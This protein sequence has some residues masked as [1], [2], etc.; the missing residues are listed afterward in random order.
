MK[1]I[2]EMHEF[3]LNERRASALT[4]LNDVVG[5]RTSS[6]EGIKLSVGMASAFLDWMRL[7][8]YGKKYGKLPFNMLFT[9]AFVWGLDRYVKGKDL[10]DEYKE[11]KAKAKEMRKNES[12]EEGYGMY[13]LDHG[14]TMGILD[15]AAQYTS[16]AHA[17]ANQMWRDVDDLVSYL[18]SDH[19]PRKYHKAF[20]KSV[21]SYKKRHKLESVSIDEEETLIYDELG[22]ELQSLEDKLND[23]TA[24]AVDP[25]WKKALV[26]IGNQLDKVMMNISK[27]D[28]KLG[29]IELTEKRSTPYGELM[30]DLD[31]AMKKAI[32]KGVTTLRYAKDYVKSLERMAKK[33][34]KQFFKDYGDFTE[35]DWIEDVRYNMANENVQDAAFNLDKIFGDDQESIQMFQDIEDNGTWK[36]MVNY[37][38]E[39][40]NEEMLKRYG[41]RSTSQVTKLAKHLMNES[42]IKGKDAGNFVKM[43]KPGRTLKIDDDVYTALGKGKWEGPKG[44]KLNWIEVSSIASALGNKKVIYESELKERRRSREPFTFSE[45]EVKDIAD[46]IAKAISKTDKVKAEVHDMEYV[47]GEGAS[48][49]ISMDGEKYDGGSYDV[50]PNGEVVN[51]A[52][53]NSF[54]N[55]IYAK[56]GDKNINQIM[57]NIKKFESAE[58]NEIRAKK[59]T[60]QMWKKFSD[61]KRFDAL[62]SVIKDPDDAEEYVF[63]R[64]EKLPG[65]MQR[66]MTLFELNGYQ[67]TALL[68]AVV[69]Q[70]KVNQ[71]LSAAN[72]SAKKLSDGRWFFTS[73]PRN[74]KGAQDMETTAKAFDEY[75][76]P[77][78]DGNFIKDLD[79]KI[80]GSGGSTKILDLKTESVLNEKDY[81]TEQ[82]KEMAAKGLALPDGSFPIK[83]IKDLKNAILSYGRSTDHS[84]VAK[85]IAKRAKALGA[86]D[87]IPDTENFQKALK[88]TDKKGEYIPY[89]ESFKQ[90]LLEKK[91]KGAPDFHH[92]D[93]PDAEGRFRDLSPKD[94]A[95]WLI[96]TRKKDLKKISGSLTQQVV[97]NRN[98]D[99]KYAD[100]MEKTRIEVYKQLGREDLLDKKD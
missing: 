16:D 12:V 30:L 71:V 19:I 96:K 36:D 33:N 82:R 92:S 48:F 98:D 11:L 80:K 87:L 66:D 7:S 72:L 97:F 78:L 1:N 99:P 90:S 10:K 13:G 8:P 25:N 51:V 89:Y 75:A 3:L 56:I 44:E 73:G 54:P 43:A 57:K 69:K 6:V 77:Q 59:V 18:K 40:G 5:G 23:L 76:L 60:K 38:E 20:D 4:L 9:A 67:A 85:F 93:A 14:D 53:G 27:Y 49:E 62:L 94:L 70:A 61:D 63:M 100:K 35:D 42:V 74:L 68:D 79:F 81:S 50:R 55:A 26:S 34:A 41:I 2:L 31:A 86:E 58:V 91:P 52:I 95:A 21:E 45:K 32:K 22:M 39:F 83:N 24:S 47:E 46:L 84:E 29:A 37:I 65:W 17:A 28:R 88:E 15:I 64:W